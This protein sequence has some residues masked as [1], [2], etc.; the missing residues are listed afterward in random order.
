[1]AGSPNEN[2]LI[3]I[4][5]PVQHGAGWNPTAGPVMKD[6]PYVLGTI[7]VMVYLGVILAWRG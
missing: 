3:A 4:P 7:L 1:M 6:W 2:V 5:V